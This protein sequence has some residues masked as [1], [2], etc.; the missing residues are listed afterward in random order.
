MRK[1][2]E[3]PKKEKYQCDTRKDINTEIIIMQGEIK[4]ICYYYY[5]RS[6]FCE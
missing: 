3:S 1:I 2:G 5:R 6:L 4:K